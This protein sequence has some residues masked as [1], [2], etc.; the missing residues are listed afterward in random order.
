ME[1]RTFRAK[2][3]SCFKLQWWQTPCDMHVS[4]SK[5]SWH[6]GGV[7]PRMPGT[8]IPGRSFPGEP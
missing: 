1:L 7:K 2:P 3:C 8:K 5:A 6:A 4:S